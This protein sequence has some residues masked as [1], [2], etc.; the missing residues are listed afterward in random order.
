MKGSLRMQLQFKEGIWKARVF[1]QSVFL[2][3]FSTLFV[4]SISA[5]QFDVED[6]V[7]ALTAQDV[8]P[9]IL[10]AQ[11]GDKEAQFMLGRAYHL[12]Q[13]VARDPSEALKWYRKAAEQGYPLAELG[14]SQL[15]L[16]GEGVNKDPEESFKWLRKAAEHGYAFAQFTYGFVVE[17]KGDPSEAAKWYRKAA[18]QGLVPA[19]NA[20][21]FMY[22]QGRGV[23]KDEKEAVNWYRKSAEQGNPN[24]QSNLGNMYL[25]GKGVTKDDAEAVKW[26]RLSADQGWSQGQAN[27]AGAYLM[28]RGVPRDFVSAYMWC[29]VAAGGQN[30]CQRVLQ[31]LNSQMK[32]EEIDEAKRRAAVWSKEHAQYVRK[33]AVAVQEPKEMPEE[34][35]KLLASAEN[36]DAQAQSN[37]GEMYYRAGNYPEA[38]KWIR[39]SAEQGYSYGQYNLGVMLME[40][41]GI[42]KDEAEA[43]KWFTKAAEQWHVAAINNLVAVYFYGKGM[44]KDLVTAYMWLRIGAV[45]GDAN[46]PSN[47]EAIKKAMTVEQI[48]EAERRASTWQAEHKKL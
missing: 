18:E 27:L 39:K 29:S 21:G 37:L 44:P 7:K 40:G 15:Y 13:A 46:S 10:K 24:A 1:L 48:N 38:L 5:T 11:S 34:V 35:K 19:Q 22:E 32:P 47:I 26:Y 14:L 45:A 8:P 28:G 20:L 30:E 25:Q 17:Q 12:G 4:S 43:V 3:V 41:S 42:A 23:R 31:V 6:R 2:L 36:G 9:L 16:S 33:G